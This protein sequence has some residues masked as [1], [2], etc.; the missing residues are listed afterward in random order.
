VEA[1]L[2]RLNRDYTVNKQ[3]YDTL[4]QRLE[5]ARISEQAEQNAENVKFRVIEPP[6]IPVKPSG[7]Q[8]A[9]LD[10]MAL[11]AALGVGAA[12]AVLLAQLHPT[13]ATRDTLQRVA[14]ISV[15]GSIAAAHSEVVIPWYRRQALLA[16]GAISMLFVVYLLNLVLSE[17]LRQA[18]RGLIS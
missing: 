9:L 1:E 7:P 18:L 15:L 8:R 10:T 3:Q 12:L 2:S 5:S 4:M 17:P 6:S 14:G 13:F 16:G 11:L